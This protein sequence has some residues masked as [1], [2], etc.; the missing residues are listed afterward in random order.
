MEEWL[1]IL[2]YLENNGVTIRTTDMKRSGKDEIVR[3]DVD[4]K[5]RTRLFKIIKHVHHMQGIKEIKWEDTEHISSNS[6]LGS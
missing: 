3:F 6:I 5:R 1:E 2:D 4:L